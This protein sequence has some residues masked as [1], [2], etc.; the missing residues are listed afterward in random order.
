LVRGCEVINETVLHKIV[1][2]CS[3]VKGKQ[4]P[5][6]QFHICRKDNL[7]SLIPVSAVSMSLRC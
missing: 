5:Q 2:V 4:D 3:F 1:K 7:S 6:L